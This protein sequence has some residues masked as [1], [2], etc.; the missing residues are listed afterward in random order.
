MMI[1]QALSIPLKGVCSW[2]GDKGGPNT[3]WFA[4]FICKKPNRFF[5]PCN[6]LAGALII[7]YERNL[8]VG[9]S[10]GVSQSQL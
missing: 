8:Q 4:Y 1:H 2:E 10:D 9:V 3:S 6:W 7:Q 5:L